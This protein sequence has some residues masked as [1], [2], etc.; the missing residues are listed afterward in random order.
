MAAAGSDLVS[1]PAGRIDRAAA[2]RLGVDPGDPWLGA[3]PANPSFRDDPAPALRRLREI[4]PVHLSP[5]GAWRLSRYEDCVR[6]LREVKCGVRYADGR[7]AI[8]SAPQGFDSGPGEF[9]LQQDPPTHTRLRRLVSK[10]FTPR[11]VEGLRERVRANVRSLLDA[12]L[13]RGEMDVIADLALPVPSTVICEMMGVPLEDRPRF[14]AWTG[15]ATHLLAAEFAPEDV[16]QRGI[17]GAGSLALYFQQLIEA[18]R[19]SD[20]DDILSDMIRAEEAGDR[21]SP[22]EL[23]VQSIGLLIAGFETTIG[24]IGNGVYQLL[25]HPGEL[26]RLR[27]EPG[28]VRTAVDECLRFDG[29]IGATLRILHEDAEFG[30]VTIPRD[31]RVIVLLEAANRDPARFPEPD[32]FDVGRSPNDHLAFGGGAHLCLGAHLARMEAQEAIVALATRTRA[33]EL[34]DEKR[35]WG[36]SLFRVPAVLPVR[37]S[38]A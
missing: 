10:A 21:L 2:R 13:A 8:G 18:R 27:R 25:R 19:G 1:T 34:L 12:A 17:A 6:L 29:P 9:M 28:L 33:I 24:L 22:S 38:P 23:L 35:S 5:M 30:G 16:V 11:A 7:P 15:D 4:A 14:T 3:D 36:R 26:A 31:S 20:S 32:R 37:I